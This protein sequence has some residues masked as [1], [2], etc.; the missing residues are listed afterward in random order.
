MAQY[1]L[2]FLSR[3]AHPPEIDAMC[4]TFSCSSLILHLCRADKS[5]NDKNRIYPGHAQMFT[6]AAGESLRQDCFATLLRSRALMLALGCA[7]LTPVAAQGADET[8]VEPHFIIGGEPVLDDTAAPWI[9]ALTYNINADLV[10]RQFCGGSVIAD[11]WVLTA[12]HCLFDRAGNFLP[13]SDYRVAINATNLLNPN[14]SELVVT[15]AIVHPEYEHNA[16]NPH[17]DIALLELATPSGIEPIALSTKSTDQ[18]IGLEATVL[19]W[20][21]TDNDLFAE[22]V[23]PDQLHSVDVPI[24]SLEVCNAPISYQ[25]AL[26]A[27]QLCAGLAEGGRDSCAG[28]SGGPLVVTIDGR[29]QQAGIV[30]FGNECALP[31]FYG[32]YT[33]VPYFIGWIN[34]FVFVGEPEFEPELLEAR[35]TEALAAGPTA[36]SEVASLNWL[37]IV[38]IGVGLSRRQRKC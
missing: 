7:W 33:D 26:L 23:F 28:D 1:V 20:G 25:G 34:Q 27:N 3:T 12:A 38:F 24:V 18:L 11:Q 6:L 21:A 19:G 29:I 5:S 31:N 30:S 15:N 9:V 32:V 13:T 8:S 17:S 2:F 37:L 14:A 35:T 4:I 36:N 16:R 10:Q 22:N